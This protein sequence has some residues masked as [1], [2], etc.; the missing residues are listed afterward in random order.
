MLI[1]LDW[2][3]KVGDAR[4][5][6]GRLSAEL[7]DGQTTGPACPFQKTMIGV[8]CRIPSNKLRLKFGCPQ[9]EL[10]SSRL[11]QSEEG[12]QWNWI[13]VNYYFQCCFY[14]RV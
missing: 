6:S 7:T 12:H 11:F 2:S 14:M 1:D 4:Y 8:F 9:R 13:D 5:P 10:N 3:G